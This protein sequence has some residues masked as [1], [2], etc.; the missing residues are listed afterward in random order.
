[1]FIIF[2][3]LNDKVE[4]LGELKT[5]KKNKMEILELKSLVN[6]VLSNGLNS[7]FDT[8]EERIGQLDNKLEE[9]TQTKT[10]GGL[11]GWDTKKEKA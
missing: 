3:K 9:N 8:A 1:M 4:N 7:K 6:R 5:M 11:E 2:K 10:C